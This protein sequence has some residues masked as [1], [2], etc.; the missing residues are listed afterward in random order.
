[1]ER[2]LTACAAGSGPARILSRDNER[3]DI[4]LSW[5]TKLVV[6]FSLA[7]IVLFDAISVG[8]TYSSVADQGSHAAHEASETWDATRDLQKA[9][10][11]ASAV[12]EEANSLN[13]VDPATFRV[14]PDAR[15]HLRITRTATTLVLYRIGP[16]EDLATIEV[17]A[18][19][20][21]VG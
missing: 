15:V 7:G 16:L 17:G 6:F 13:E 12:A 4:V 3:G 19:G 10:L 8:V 20:R 2:L 21:S 18:T 14:D 11:A 9:Y 5:L 1:M